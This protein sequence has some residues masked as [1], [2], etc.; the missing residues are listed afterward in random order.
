MDMGNA[1]LQRNSIDIQPEPGMLVIFPSYL[2]HKAMPYE[3]GND[4]IIISFNAQI[5]ARTGNQIHNYAAR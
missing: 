2:A 3:G 5:N 1:Y 4:R